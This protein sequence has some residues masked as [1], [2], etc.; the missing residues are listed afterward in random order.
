[1]KKERWAAG[2]LAAGCIALALAAKTL[3]FMSGRAYV[4]PQDI[5]EMAADVLRHR[6]TLSYEAEAEDLSADDL[7]QRLLNEL[8]TP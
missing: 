2:I 8:R 6:L 4:V 5:K 1:M 7:I 3:A